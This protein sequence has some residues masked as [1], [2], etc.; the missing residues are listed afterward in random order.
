M[1]G[2]WD[3]AGCSKRGRSRDT[4]GTA[5]RNSHR[6]HRLFRCSAAV[7]ASLALV[8]VGCTNPPGTGGA[9]PTTT[10]V[11][12][13][14]PPGEFSLLSY[15]VAGLP[16]EISE[17]HPSAHIPL[18]SPRLNPY[19]VVLTQEDFDWWQP[20][21]DGLDFAGYHDALRAQADHPYRS[22]QH[23][24]PL[25]VG[26]DPASRPLFVGDGLGVMA[27]FPFS[28]PLRVPWT[29]CFGGIL[30]DGGAADCLAMKGFSVTTMT[31][32]EGHT[33]DVYNLH[34]EAGSTA[35]DQELQA[36][37]YEQL[38]EFMLANSAGRPVILA[39]D[40][41]LHIDRN[42]PEDPDFDDAAIWAEF[43]SVTGLTDTCA[44]LSCAEG[45][46][47]DKAAYR[48]GAG[49]DLTPLSHTYPASEFRAPSGE[50]L[51]DHLPLVVGFSWDDD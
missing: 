4:S 38:A 31:L 30:P 43:L 48:D 35:R 49:L 8:V 47:I 28:E 44:E 16:Q 42:G 32:A 9:P 1:P 6:G 15:N 23:P 12:L 41:N 37:D 39:G 20:L 7:V 26:L 50:D 3:A 27:R 11:P 14:G 13:P 40:T 24:G 18:I 34:A 21:L 22:G 17:V 29:G 33:V 46:S 5:K 25:A 51:S 2:S 10:I 19:D 36:A 45:A